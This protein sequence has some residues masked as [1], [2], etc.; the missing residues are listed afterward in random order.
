MRLATGFL[1]LVVPLLIPPPSTLGQSGNTDLTL[2]VAGLSVVDGDVATQ[3]GDSGDS[4]AATV[5]MPLVEGDALHLKGASRAEVQLS[6]DNFVRATGDTEIHFQELARQRFFINLP[7][8][9]AVYSELEGSEADVDIETPLVAVQPTKP[10]RY[11]ITVMPDWTFVAVRQGETEILFEGWTTTL[12]TGEGITVWEGPDGAAFELGRAGSADRFDRWVAGRDKALR[13]TISHRYLSRDIYGASTLDD[14]GSWRN[15]ADLGPCWFPRV[16]AGWVP[17]RQGRWLW[18]DYYGWTWVSSE[19][20]GWAPYHWGRWHNHSLYGWGWYPGPPNLRHVWRPALVAFFAF[21]AVVS[22][23]VWAGF[24][25]IGWTPL[26]PGE[27]YSPWYGTRHYGNS[28]IDID[29]SIH[30]YDTYRNARERHAVSYVNS[31]RFALGSSHTPRALRTGEI[32][33]AVAILGPLPVVPDRA[34]Q[35]VVL[36]SSSSSQGARNLRSLRSGYP[37]RLR[38]GTERISFEDQRERMQASVETFYRGFRNNVLAPPIRD[39]A[40]PF[41]AATVTHTY[42]P[43]EPIG[44][45]ATRTTEGKVLRPLITERPYQSGRVQSHLRIP[46]E[47]HP[48]QSIP[49]L[50][51][52]TP[53]SPSTGGAGPY[54]GTHVGAPSP[55]YAPSTGSPFGVPSPDVGSEAGG[56][57]PNTADTHPE[58]SSQSRTAVPVAVTPTAPTVYRPEAPSSGRRTGVQAPRPG[59]GSYN[60]VSTPRSGPRVGSHSPPGTS[61]K[62]S[63]PNGS[64]TPSPSSRP[65]TRVNSN[66]PRGAS[67]MGASRPSARTGRT[68]RSSSRPSYRR[69]TFGNSGQR[70]SRSGGTSGGRISP[71]PSSRSSTAPRVGGL[72]TQRSGRGSSSVP[73]MSNPRPSSSGSRPSYGGSRPSYG[74]SGRTPSRPSSSSRPGS[75]SGAGASSSSS[76]SGT[77]SD[78]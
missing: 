9:T 27:P 13:R 31:R 22:P 19:P 55:V 26:A 37:S 4:I 63:R 46:G 57:R 76:R 14:H 21:E 68:A 6:R 30:V 73:R 35:G 24:G 62:V 45:A 40:Y 42:R 53:T 34:S 78:R 65:S 77:P 15:V 28:K 56:T 32:R 8:G 33:E 10:G 12:S 2:G 16:S 52:S 51:S 54:A 50:G 71:R 44:F 58:A 70:G 17:Y 74:G 69:G 7:R 23:G 43:G 18:I 47:A 1:P 60:S 11:R 29:R 49:V 67:R 36:R 20:W 5:N 61:T 72:S 41:E 48:P 3:R 75:W 59:T 66:F 25:R 38:D 64:R 39:D